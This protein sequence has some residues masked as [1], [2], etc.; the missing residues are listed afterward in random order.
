MNRRTFLAFLGLAPMAATVAPALPALPPSVP[1][2]RRWKAMTPVQRRAYLD[3]QRQAFAAEGYRCGPSIC[4]PPWKLSKITPMDF[5]ASS[6]SGRDQFSRL[7][8]SAA[9]W[10]PPCLPSP[11]AGVGG[12]ASR[13]LCVGAGPTNSRVRV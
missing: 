2:W 5:D 7:H 11:P 4:A 12:P 3:V 10:T 6:L 9:S 8:Q 1:M 13:P